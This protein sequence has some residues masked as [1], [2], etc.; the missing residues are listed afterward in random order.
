MRL[1]IVGTHCAWVTRWRSISRSAASGVEALHHDDRAAG[2]VGREA[3]VERAR[4]VERAGREPHGVGVEPV[5]VAVRR[6]VAGHRPRRFEGERLAHAL[7]ATGRARRVE[8]LAPGDLGLHRARPAR[9]SWASSYPVNPSRAPPT[10]SRTR[11]RGNRSP[12]PAAAGQ[13]RRRD[14]RHR[15]AVV[16]HVVELGA[17]EQRAD[18]R[19]VEA[20]PLRRPHDLHVRRDRSRGRSRRGR[21]VRDPRPGRAARA[22]STACRAART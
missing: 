5:Q 16:D 18:R 7:G 20:R 1:N 9:A 13:A 21:R 3:P 6:E 14:Q 15:A 12:I 2:A 10:A 11:T 19:V 4:V 8:H 22:G 17:G